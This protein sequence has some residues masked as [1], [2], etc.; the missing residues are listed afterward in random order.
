MVAAEG[1][2]SLFE[3]SAVEK[4]AGNLAVLAD[5]GRL[6]GAATG[7]AVSTLALAV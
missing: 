1:K 7:L 6:G 4:F 2:F 3:I 5:P